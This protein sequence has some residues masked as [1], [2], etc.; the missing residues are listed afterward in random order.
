M[1]FLALGSTLIHLLK[2][3]LKV[4][5]RYKID[6]VKKSSWQSDTISKN[7]L[8]SKTAQ[9]WYYAAQLVKVAITIEMEIYKLQMTPGVVSYSTVVLYI[10]IIK[11]WGFWPEIITPKPA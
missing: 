9:G 3:S 1:K 7:I 11:V 6:R 10:G 2:N 5:P 4:Q 8:V